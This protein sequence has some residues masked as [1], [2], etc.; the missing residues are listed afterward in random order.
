MTLEAERNAAPPDLVI[1]DPVAV[2]RMLGYGAEALRR[3]YPCATSTVVCPRT[4]L[5]VA[6]PRKEMVWPPWGLDDK[7]RPDADAWLCYQC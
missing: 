5:E 2:D 3:C 6:F 1:A 4:P 7:L